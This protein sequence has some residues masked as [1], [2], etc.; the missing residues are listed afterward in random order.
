MTIYWRSKGKTLLDRLNELYEKAGYWEEMGI[1]K[2]FQGP[3]GP[4]TMA[5]VMAEYRK[6]PPRTLGG[7]AVVK[8]RDVQEGV[9]T[10]ISDPSRKERTDLPKSNVLQFYLED[11]TIVSARPSGTEPKIKFYATCCGQTGHGGLEAAKK[12]VSEKLAAINADIRKVIG[13]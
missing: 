4:A 5:G 3:Q 10:F 8:V 6:N 7:I 13:A 1:S 9:V 11:G 12:E 2:Y